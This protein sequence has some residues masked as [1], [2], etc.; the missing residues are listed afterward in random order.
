MVLD[1]AVLIAAGR[2]HLA[3]QAQGLSCE[4]RSDERRGFGQSQLLGERELRRADDGGV[5]ALERNP[6]R[7]GYGVAEL[8]G[9]FVQLTE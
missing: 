8:L 2:E 3:A 9:I 1:I 7:G 4:A 6:R 5:R